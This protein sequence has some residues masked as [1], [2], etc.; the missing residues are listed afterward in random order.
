[1]VVNQLK[2]KVALVT[3]GSSGI[4]RSIALLFAREGA[5]VSICSRSQ[6]KGEKVV[7]EIQKHNGEAMFIQTDVSKSEEVKRVVKST[8]GRYGNIHILCNNAGVTFSGT[9]V[10]TSEKEWD[11]VMDINVKGTYLLSKYVIPKMIENGGGN[12]I[13]IASCLSFIA[14]EGNA[15]YCTSKAAMHHL[16]RCM[17]LDFAKYNIRVNSICPGPVI[18]PNYNRIVPPN[19]DIRK[20]EIEM[21]PMRRIAKPEEVASVALF[22]ATNA[23]SYMTGSAVLVDGG[24]TIY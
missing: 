21:I 16:T 24:W 14:M 3:G 10:N 6:I 18:T 20:R 17:A 19:S 15:V 23:S 8:I 5:K 13:N 7:N 9:V 22:L 2:G 1:M 12:I 4:G 11:R